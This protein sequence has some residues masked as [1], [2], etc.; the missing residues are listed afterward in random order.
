LLDVGCG[1]GA[2]L[3]VAKEVIPETQ[4]TGLDPVD[5]VLQIA[6][7][8]L[9]AEARLCRGWAE[10]L[11]FRSGRFPAVVCCNAFHYFSGPR[12]TLDE[13]YRVLE[14]GGR[15]VLT[16]WCADYLSTRILGWCL[17]ATGKPLHRVYSRPAL[18][19]LLTAAGFRDIQ[20]KRYR[21]DWLWGLMTVTARK[22]DNTLA[23]EFDCDDTRA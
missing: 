17:R 6:R 4:L 20:T 16:D 12:R 21:I 19:R 18:G 5:A 2:L 11:P 9:G 7:A 10:G 15:L 1:T 8:K 23:G 3:A 14:P 22:R 13:I